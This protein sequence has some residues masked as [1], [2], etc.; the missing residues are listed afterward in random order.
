M[1]SS[2]YILK[3]LDARDAPFLLLRMVLGMSASDIHFV[4][5][6]FGRTQVQPVAVRDCDKEGHR[7]LFAKTALRRYLQMSEP[8]S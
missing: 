8:R 5:V 3:W 4:D 6:W 1:D 7:S 2:G